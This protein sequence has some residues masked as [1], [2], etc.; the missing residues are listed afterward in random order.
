VWTESRFA[1]R[2]RLA[3]I[4]TST[5]TGAASKN[6]TH[7]GVQSAGSGKNRALRGADRCDRVAER[8]GD[9]PRLGSDLEIARIAR[10]D[11]VAHV[12]VEAGAAR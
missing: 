6:A 12:V 10:A 7:S 11:V 8:R 4:G 9:D 3:L 1:F 5:W 2:Y